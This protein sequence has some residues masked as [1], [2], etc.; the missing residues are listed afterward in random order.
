[1]R[2]AKQAREDLQNAHVDQRDALKEKLNSL[3]MQAATEFEAA[4]QSVGGND[5]NLPLLWTKLAAAYELGG[6]DDDAIKAYHRAIALKP[7]TASYYCELGA[8]FARQGKM[9]EAGNMYKKSAELDPP[10]AA[11][12]WRNFGIVL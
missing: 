6:R 7:D 3:G 1:V 4:R 10:N 5:P 9:E 2:Q 12:A 8:V 11:G